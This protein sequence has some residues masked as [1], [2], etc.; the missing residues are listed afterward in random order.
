MHKI[1]AGWSA[2]ADAGMAACS[3]CGTAM[4][5]DGGKP[6][7]IAA[8][9]D[10]R[11]LA[12]DA[13]RRSEAAPAP[14]VEDDPDPD[15][16]APPPPK[17]EKP[18]LTRKPKSF[19]RT[20]KTIQAEKA[21]FRESAV[22]E[23]IVE[24]FWESTTKRDG[25]QNAR[26]GL[27]VAVILPALLLFFGM[28]AGVIW[29]AVA[30]LVGFAIAAVRQNPERLARHT[31]RVRADA[32]EVDDRVVPRA[33]VEGVRV[34]STADGLHAVVLE[35]A[36]VVVDQTSKLEHARW[37]EEELQRELEASE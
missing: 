27:A 9:A 19:S 20:T 1:E 16:P 17:V 28:R 10:A 2:R 8:D 4:R 34:H 13:K 23:K 29:L 32:I 18:K 15:P 24:L 21:G 33:R 6:S 36:D 14:V 26:I 30:A 35:G 5:L 3:S 11:D 22:P 25:T 7:W 37:I 31:V 12:R